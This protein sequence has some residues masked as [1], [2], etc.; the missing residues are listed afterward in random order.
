ML[1]LNL[2]L[3]ESFRCQAMA[4]EILYRHVDL[5]TT[6]R[7]L[8]FVEAL[9]SKPSLSRLVHSLR[10]SLS[11]SDLSSY[12][13]LLSPHIFPHL[14]VHSGIISANSVHDPAL[15][16]FLSQGCP[17]LTSLNLRYDHRYSPKPCLFAPLLG[18]LTHLEL[19]EARFASSDR[20]L[21][22]TLS[23][24][25]FHLP[26]NLQ[27]LSLPNQNGTWIARFHIY[28]SILHRLLVDRLSHQLTHLLLVPVGSVLPSFLPSS[29]RALRSFSGG[30]G[31]EVDSWLDIARAREGSETLEVL[32][33]FV[34]VRGVGT[35]EHSRMLRNQ[36]VLD[37]ARVLV[38]LDLKEEE[39]TRLNAL[40]DQFGFGA[41]DDDENEERLAPARKRF[42][43][44]RWMRFSGY[45]VE[46]W[47]GLKGDA[48]DHWDRIVSTCRRFGFG[49]IDDEGR[50]WEG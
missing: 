9:R 4:T 40:V 27:S 32:G 38:E 15:L 25:P 41:D 20:S 34:E 42:P 28:D 45:L 13:T 43:A 48:K 16:H 3:I 36:E 44:L 24:L 7:T 8:S 49:V 37:L 18:R 14:R 17:S 10:S 50:V 11:S 26:L 22:F 2:E 31:A 35:G 21:L 30:A 5:P 46:D 29:L 39:T 6:E 1:L 12:L 33:R 47:A 19:M 23:T